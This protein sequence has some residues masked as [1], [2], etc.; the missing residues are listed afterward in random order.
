MFAVIV[1]TIAIIL[2]T[3]IG[4]VIRRGISEQLSNEVLRA[5]GLCTLVI[6]IQGALQTS[7]VLILILAVAFGLAIGEI[8]RLEDKVNSGTDR[9]LAKFTRGKQGSSSKLTE[10]FVTS[11]LIMNVGAMVIVGSLQAGLQ[12]DFTMLYTK[13][14]LD[15][16]SGIV[17]GAALGVGVLGSAVFTLIF[18][19]AIV[20]FSEYLAPYLA[21]EMVS[22]LSACGCVLIMALGF[23]MTKISSF[24]VINYLPALLLVP[25]V[26]KLIV[27]LGV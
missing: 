16:I 6:G 15:F 7:N 21:D 10:A 11:C 19:G 14:L 5:L 4:L 17:M 25:P 26:M 20:L 13:S 22:E 23:N 12:G 9:I 1:N 3:L 2:G 18:Q 27:A 8:L 24:K